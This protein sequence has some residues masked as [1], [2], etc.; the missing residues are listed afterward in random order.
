[1][2]SAGLSRKG[3]SCGASWAHCP[4]KGETVTGSTLISVGSEESDIS[5]S[6]LKGCE[7][8]GEAVQG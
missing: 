1:M 4:K 6:Q 2:D 5:S 7:V 8:R 3:E